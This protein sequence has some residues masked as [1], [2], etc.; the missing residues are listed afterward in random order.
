M[1]MELLFPHRAGGGWADTRPWRG[2]PEMVARR[3]SCILYKP[4]DGIWQVL[5]KRRGV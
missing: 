1:V 4:E 3:E 5:D 2:D